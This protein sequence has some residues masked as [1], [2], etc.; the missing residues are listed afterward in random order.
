MDR[1]IDRRTQLY[2]DAVLNGLLSIGQ[3][4]AALVLRELGIPIETA[5]RV[6][7]RPQERRRAPHGRE[8][9]T[10]APARP[11]ARARLLSS[12]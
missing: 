6:I 5:I 11:D 8:A 4:E 1:R 12:A 3:R 9:T 10:E 2:I 7:T